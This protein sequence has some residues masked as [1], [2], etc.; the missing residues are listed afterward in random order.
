VSLIEIPVRDF[1]FNL[2]ET[3]SIIHH[4]YII[5]EYQNLVETYTYTSRRDYEHIHTHI[6]ISTRCAIICTYTS[7][8]LHSMHKR[9]YTITLDVEC[10]DDLPIHDIDWAKAINLFPDEYIHSSICER[11]LQDV[12]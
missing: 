4:L 8:L 2:V 1:S 12:L 11:E 7:R 5:L 9:C 3:L 6:D 10:W